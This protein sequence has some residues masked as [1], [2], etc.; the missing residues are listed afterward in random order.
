MGLAN[1]ARLLDD[2]RF[3]TSLWNTAFYTVAST[4]PI[5]AIPLA[6]ALA[7]NRGSRC[8]RSSGARSSSRSRS[9]WSR[10]A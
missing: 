2:T 4:L 9:R 7:L 10:W 3:H 1:Y 6:L 5:L 8:A